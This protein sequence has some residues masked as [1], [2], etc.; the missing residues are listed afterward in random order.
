MRRIVVVLAGA[1]PLLAWSAGATILALTCVAAIFASTSATAEVPW[2]SLIIGVVWAVPGVLIASGRPRIPVGWLILASA[3]VF[4]GAGAS[5]G[6]LAFAAGAGINDGLDWAA[7]FADRF[8]AVLVPLTFLTLILLPDGR[9]P[10]KGWKPVTWVVCA[11]QLATV[12]A[13][14]LVG[15]PAVAPESDLPQSVHR[16]QNPVGVLPEGLVGP[17]TV[18][19]P[20]ILQLPLLL[21]PL[22][23]AFR[24]WR[25]K[26]EERTRIAS[27]LLAATV[28]VLLLV[29]GRAL[30]PG[31]AEV[32]DIGAG[33]F[34]AVVVTTA[35]LRRR[36]AGVDIVV[37]HA[38]LFAVLTVIIAGAYAL[39]VTVAAVSSQELPPFGVGIIAALVA[40]AALPLRG[41][42]QLLVDRLL[43]GDRNKPYEAVRRL[44]DRT[45]SATTLHELLDELASTIVAS[46]RVPWA[47]V[48]LDGA[49]ATSGVRPPGALEIHAPLISQ[50][51]QIGTVAA[52]AGAGRT[53]RRR[54][55]TLL[56]ALGQHGG[57]AV[58]T[59]L[60]AEAVI[61]SRNRVVVG[62]EEERR[63]LS[64]D[65]HDEL[66][67]TMASIS[68]QLGTLR[69]I[70]STDPQTVERR[71]G[72]LEQTAQ[73]ALNSV[74]YLA[75]NLRPT[76]LDELGLEAAL[77]R[78][79]EGLGLELR[80]TATVLPTLS[81]AVE[82]AAYRI[83]VEALTNVARHAG[84]RLAELSISVAAG[85][86]VLK[87]EDV[88]S[89]IDGL[90]IRGVGTIGM[91]ERAE[92][93]G[94][95][96]TLKSDK[97]GTT[98][99]ATLPLHGSPEG[100][101]P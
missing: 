1:G 36:L 5:S 8:A 2:K 48:E 88:G 74:R 84:T 42:L 60:L 97:H 23:F 85:Y 24:L 94:G 9:L 21:C 28:F 56:A 98:V 100:R 34:F 45:H 66:G 26:G 3:L 47:R 92:E 32:L 53:L 43:Y 57:M 101:L 6:W 62:R 39:A 38:V 65:L 90:A 86:L 54:D 63:A 70:V 25:A 30:W 52:A 61:A 20:L 58:R 89:G 78:T 13:W 95:G 93:L 64:R 29:I 10:S 50:G 80:I 83:A 99:T 82:V 72:Q 67:P 35:V 15:G 17:L 75:K 79:A 31:V 14:T 81:A 87:V 7:W 18:L 41:W 37:H 68:M 46:L 27:V 33:I 4:A 96:L 40:V 55:E 19:E 44:V 71:L 16:V 49:D 12:L 73:E 91:R 69:R 77:R 22:A 51:Q 11:L 76:V 59:M